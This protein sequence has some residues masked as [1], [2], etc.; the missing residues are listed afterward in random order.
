MSA[1]VATVVAASP[2]LVVSHRARQLVM[3][4]EHALLAIEVGNTPSGKLATATTPFT[5]P[6][7]PTI[8]PLYP[9]HTP[10]RRCPSPSP[11]TAAAAP[12]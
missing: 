11:S 4:S 1:G 3:F 2:D 9:T 12:S 5:H 8:P 7:A 6:L 10:T